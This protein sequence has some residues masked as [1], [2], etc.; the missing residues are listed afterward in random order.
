MT[1]PEGNVISKA[2]EILD[3]AQTED[4]IQEAIRIA[5]EISEGDDLHPDNEILNEP[6]ETGDER[7]TGSEDEGPS[8]FDLEI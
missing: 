5:D 6:I 7:K 1:P 8:G 2:S 3:L 4:D